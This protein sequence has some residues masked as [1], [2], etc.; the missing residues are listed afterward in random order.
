MDPRLVPEAD[1]LTKT[2]FKS[3]DTPALFTLNLNAEERQGTARSWLR[4]H[5]NNLNKRIPIAL[6]NVRRF[7]PVYAWFVSG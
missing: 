4:S 7:S 2:D 1:Q 6:R 5:L 3:L